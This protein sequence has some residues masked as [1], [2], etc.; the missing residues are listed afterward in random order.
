MSRLR[1][2]ALAVSVAAM[3]SLAIAGPASAG[4]ILNGID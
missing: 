2:I 1:R 3:T 4:I